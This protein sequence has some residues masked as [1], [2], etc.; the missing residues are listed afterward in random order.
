MLV[1][2]RY[3][4]QGEVS[5]SVCTT[6]FDICTYQ[7]WRDFSYYA[8]AKTLTLTFTAQAYVATTI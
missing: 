7:C 8:I 5:V 6:Q 2:Y 1:Y 4:N 3:M